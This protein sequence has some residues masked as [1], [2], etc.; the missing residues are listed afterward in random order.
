MRIVLYVR[1]AEL[2]EARSLKGKIEEIDKVK[3]DIVCMELTS[4]DE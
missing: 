1:K 2:A 3:I 4:N